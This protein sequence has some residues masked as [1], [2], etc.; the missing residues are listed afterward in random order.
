[1]AK[2]VELGIHGLNR[3]TVNCLEM[4]GKRGVQT[5]RN[6][7]S[8]PPCVAKPEISRRIAFGQG[9]GRAGPGPGRKTPFA[10]L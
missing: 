9:R 3:C 10:P 4:S 7:P 6:G 2:R 1:M 8:P 5:D